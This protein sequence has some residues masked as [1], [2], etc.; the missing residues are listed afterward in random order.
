MY[1]EVYQVHVDNKYAITEFAVSVIGTM[2][3]A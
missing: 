3:K 2:F 1:D